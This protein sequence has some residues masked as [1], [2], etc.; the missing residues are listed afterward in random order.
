MVILILS[1]LHPILVLTDWWGGEE[2]GEKEGLAVGFGAPSCKAL[3]PSSH[4]PH[5]VRTSVRSR[6]L[7]AII[8]TAASLEI[9]YINQMLDSWINSWLFLLGGQRPFISR[10]EIS[11]S[12]RQSYILYHQRQPPLGL[13]APTPMSGQHVHLGVLSGGLVPPQNPFTM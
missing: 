2:R 13:K 9:I 8:G 3:C 11:G 10:A 12:R 5:W 4:S 6:P 7:G 1:G